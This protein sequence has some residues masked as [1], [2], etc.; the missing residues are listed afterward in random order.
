MPAERLTVDG[1]VR[2]ASQRALHARVERLTLDPAGVR[3]DR[4]ELVPAAAVGEVVGTER[5]AEHLRDRDEDRVALEVPDPG[6]RPPEVVDVE[7]ADGQP[8]AVPVGPG[9]LERERLVE[10]LAV[11]EPGQRVDAASAGARLAALSRR[12]DRGRRVAADRLAASGSRCR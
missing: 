8:A 10:R 4:G 12:L 1:G 6:V 7:A 9:D 11:A 5:L 3:Q 2:P